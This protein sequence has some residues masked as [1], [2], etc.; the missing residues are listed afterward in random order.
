MEAG[1]ISTN[2]HAGGSDVGLSAA[3]VK[4]DITPDDL[5]GL[6]PVGGGSFVDVHDPICVRTLLLANREIEVA[7]ISLDLIEVGDMRPIR[8][9]I[10]RTLGIP[11]E[12][13][14]ICATHTHSAPRLGAVSPGAIAHELS[15]EAARYGEN[16][17]ERMLDSLQRAREALRPARVGFG[18]GAVD[19]NINRDQ[20]IDGAYEI[21]RN[22]TGPSDKTLSVIDVVGVDG[23]PIAVLMV[24]G[25]HPTVTLGTKTVSGDI[26]GAAERH[27]EERMGGDV[28]A[29]WAAGAIGD[30]APRALVPPSS[31]QTAPTDGS[32][33]NLPF[34]LAAAQGLLVANEALWVRSR[35]AHSLSAPRIGAAELVTRLPARHRPPDGMKTIRQER[36]KDVE[37]RVL[38]LMVG[39]LAVIGIGGEVT[40][41][42]ARRARAA[43]PFTH[44]ILVSLANDRLGYLVEDECYARNTFGALGA[45][46]QAGHAERA[47]V[48]AV[49][50]SAVRAGAIGG[51]G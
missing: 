26:A 44:T 34:E 9:R 51:E 45:P 22:S 43:S 14:L 6:H 42:L 19:I 23:A 18:A 1:K 32:G 50:K 47:V 40:A 17:Y 25:V 7:I 20:L 10:E 48:D 39:P 46:I 15:A 4:C 28:V 13:I 2:Q 16:V 41:D 12:H 33:G 11:R 36:V 49:G 27:V 38:A 29:L 35:I 31:A 30:Q 8:E 21:G 24:Y 5:R 3:A 37:L